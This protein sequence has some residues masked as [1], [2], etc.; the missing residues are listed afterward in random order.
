MSINVFVNKRSVI[1]A[2]LR[3]P[4]ITFMSSSGRLARGQGV[5]AVTAAEGDAMPGLPVAALGKEL[6]I[7]A[8]GRRIGRTVLSSRRKYCGQ[9]EPCAR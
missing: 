1:K 2:G 7:H 5:D 6:A 3:R 9:P 8:A 4:A